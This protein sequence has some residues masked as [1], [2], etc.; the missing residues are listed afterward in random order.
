MS[1]PVPRYTSYPT[2]AQFRD[3][4]GARDFAEA[5]VKL[6]RDAP[7]SLYVHIP[8]CKK[9]C[10][11]CGCN[12]KVARTQGP[13]ASYLEALDAELLTLAASDSRTTRFHICTGAAAR[14]IF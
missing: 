2:A 10:W 3:T 12:M 1:A 5:L 14:R 11:Y 8:F 6:E 7:F 9:L 13:I 4:V